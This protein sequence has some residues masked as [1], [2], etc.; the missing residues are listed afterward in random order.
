MPN[1]RYYCAINI[2]KRPPVLLTVRGLEDGGK[3]PLSKTVMTSRTNKLKSVTEISR[4][5]SSTGDKSN[6]L[7]GE[8]NNQ[9]IGPRAPV[10]LLHPTY[11]KV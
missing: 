3:C 6:N 7:L 11:I 1:E 2:K 9:N 10:N 5:L 8:D 4:S